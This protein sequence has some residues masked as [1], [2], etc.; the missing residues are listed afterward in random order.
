[1]SPPSSRSRNKPSKK[2]VWKQVASRALLA[3][4]FTPL[5]CLAYFLTL[6]MET[7]CSSETSVDFQWTTQHYIRE[8]RTLRTS[9]TLHGVMPQKIVLFIATIVRSSDLICRCSD[10]VFLMKVVEPNCCWYC[11]QHP[12][13]WCQITIIKWDDITALEAAV[14]TKYDFSV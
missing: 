2:L 10:C 1:M 7:T 3:A 12:V 6:K 9:S 5:S 11:L 13:Y 4:S 14:R 8:D